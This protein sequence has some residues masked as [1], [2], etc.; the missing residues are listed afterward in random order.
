MDKRERH[1]SG[2]PPTC[3]LVCVRLDGHGATMRV[4][5]DGKR[6]L[7]P[8][9]RCERWGGPVRAA[10]EAR[11][12]VPGPPRH[13][14]RRGA[15]PMPGVGPDR[16]GGRERSDDRVGDQVRRGSAGPAPATAGRLLASSTESGSWLRTCT[17]KRLMLAAKR[18]ITWSRAHGRLCG[19]F[20]SRVESAGPRDARLTTGLEYHPQPDL[21]AAYRSRRGGQVPPVGTSL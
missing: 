5:L 19:R 9:C 6:P 14:H 7:R 2:W 21:P 11:Q 12:A 4:R 15:G 10:G 20:A 3:G 1:E 18:P 8:E 16:F 17:L 13:A